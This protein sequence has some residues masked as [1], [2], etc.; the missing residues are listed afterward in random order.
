MY[1]TAS[2]KNLHKF[3]HVYIIL[4]DHVI[5]QWMLIARALH[6]RWTNVCQVCVQGCSPVKFTNQTYNKKTMLENIDVVFVELNISL[7][8]E[9]VWH[10]SYINTHT[11]MTRMYICCICYPR[12][13]AVG[14]GTDSTGGGLQLGNK[15]GTT[16]TRHLMQVC[17]AC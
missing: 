3:C 12:I 14:E 8:N 5:S 4:R 16:K 6:G 1:V 9:F 10:Y 7:N 13:V 15:T 11:H 17:C 2:A